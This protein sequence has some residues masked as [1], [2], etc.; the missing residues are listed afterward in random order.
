MLYGGASR[1]QAHF[2]CYSTLT[3]RICDSR[4]ILHKPFPNQPHKPLILCGLF[5]SARALVYFIHFIK[6]AN[7]D[8]AEASLN[9]GFQG[10]AKGLRI[11][12]VSR[13]SLLFGPVPARLRHSS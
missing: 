8:P 9:D 6:D 10:T 7:V 1:R 13:L 11:L 12:S 4:V 3:V 5:H 2:S